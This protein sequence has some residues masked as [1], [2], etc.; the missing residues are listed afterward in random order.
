[1][2]QS[3][4]VSAP[5]PSSN[6]SPAASGRPLYSFGVPVPHVTVHLIQP[7]RTVP[8]IIT[9]EPSGSQIPLEGVPR[10]GHGLPVGTGAS[11]PA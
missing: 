9:V 7:N 8:A 3:T 11:A 5:P 6:F 1:M 4:F 2:S 10:R